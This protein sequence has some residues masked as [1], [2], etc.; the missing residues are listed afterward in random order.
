MPNESLGLNMQRNWTIGGKYKS[1][2]SAMM[3]YIIA[4]KGFLTH[5]GSRVNLPLLVVMRNS[6]HSSRELATTIKTYSFSKTKH[7]TWVYEIIAL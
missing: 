3:E 6:L 2:A 5:N 1:T 4:G 7:S